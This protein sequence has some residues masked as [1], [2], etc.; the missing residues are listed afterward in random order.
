MQ[1]YPRTRFVSSRRKRSFTFD[2]KLLMNGTFL[3]IV[4]FGLIGFIV[5]LFLVF[6][7]F[8]RDLPTPG[9][10]SNPDLQDSTKILDKNGVVLFSFYKDY[11]RQYVSFEKIPTLLKEATIA[12]EDKDFY[13]NSGFSA[14]SW[15][16]I[17]RDLVFYH[18]LIGGST[19]TQQL[20]KNVLLTPE[21]TP[22]R[23]LKE[24][25][26]AVQVDKRYTKDQIL[27]MYLNN[28]PYGG[29]AVGVEAASN[30]YFG[31]QV[32][33]LN[34]VESA[35]IAGVT[36]SPTYYSPFTNKA[37]AYIDRTTYVL[38]RMEEDS[39]ISKSQKEAALKDL[40]NL[41]FVNTPSAI[42]AP[43]FVMDV[44]EKLTKMFGE[45]IV[46]KGNLTIK[47]TLDYEIQ[48][49][50]EVIL[51]EELDKLK[52]YNVGNGSVV[53]LD[54]KT[55]AVLAMVGSKNYFDTDNDGN[56]NAAVSAK[57]QPGSSLKPI[58]YAVAL[59]KGY[60]ASTVLMDVKT[61]FLADPNY[62]VY[63]PV[64]YDGKFY[65]PIQMR[66]ALGNS[67]NIPAVKML[68]KVGIKPVMQKAYDMGIENW[69][70]TTENLKNVGLSLVLGGR[71][72]TLL[73]ITSAY[74]V[75]AAQGIKKEA[76]EVEE[77]KDSKGKTLYKHEDTSGIRVLSPEVSFIISHILL[78]NNAR[79]MEF[80]P[81]S[82]LVV[83]GKT[84]SVKTG[85]TDSK[86]DN[87]TI[88]YT[89]SY[90]AG[91]WVGNNN[92]EPMNPRLASGITGAAPIWNRLMREILKDKKDE[93]F[94][95]PDNVIA[96]EIDALYGGLPIDGQPKRTEYFIKGTEPT[97]K[98][99][100]YKQVKISQHDNNKLANDEEI[101]R[102][103]FDV[104]EFIVFSEDDP[105]S[106]DGKN[107]WQEAVNAWVNQTYKD[108]KKYNPPT[109]VSSF[110][111]SGDDRN[112]SPTSTPA[113]TNTPTPTTIIPSVTI[114]P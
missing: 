99:P 49:K 53:I 104:K 98:S 96:V 50:A 61:D 107:R 21:R 94:N 40:Q 108:D 24:L 67:L 52:G 92:N 57:R 93:Q 28:V 69:Q 97:T 32:S 48:K 102:N 35:F 45:D 33:E 109:E 39:Y 86:R 42:K 41:K 95:K 91:V 25:I 5:L 37:K 100:I 38:N 29:T 13:K 73:Q 51:R 55:G 101:K 63:S 68:A 26:L 89:P 54:P 2:P 11:N 76:F 75:F 66:F 3:K 46:E 64:N 87:W 103:D 31:K 9:K 43:H 44:R 20:V 17:A 78:D 112:S 6:I 8:S 22:T 84:V 15:L 14:V 77:V 79:Q 58:T 27:E 85:T 113:P 60:T 62:P 88:G 110:T 47:T 56:Y 111:Y 82:Y 106:K 72:T 10:L 114:T 90:V 12:S 80:G 30:L 70:P 83:P 23:K 19:I 34:L 18:R 71:E 36:Q 65:G 105:V 59:E 1:Y 16:R 81:S 4:F 7:Y 74:S